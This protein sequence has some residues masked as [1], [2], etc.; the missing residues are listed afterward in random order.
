MV[1]LNTNS[2]I[3]EEVFSSLEYV[4]EIPS[5][6]LDFVR[7]K[8]FKRP[9][10]PYRLF[11]A[12][13]RQG[14]TFYEAAKQLHFRAAALM[15]YYAFLNLAKARIALTEPLFVTARVG[16]GLTERRFSPGPLSRQAV[17]TTNGSGVFPKFYEMEMRRAIPS[18]LRLSILT[19]FAY[20]SDVKSEFERAYQSL[21]RLCPSKCRF[22]SHQASRI[23][24]PYVA[25]LGF[26]KLRPYKKALSDFGKYFEMVQPNREL[27]HGVFDIRAES[28]LNYTYFQS[29][30]TYPWIQDD[31]IQHGAMTQDVLGACSQLYEAKIYDD[32]FDFKLA[33]PLR[34]N[35]QIPFNQPLSIYAAMFYIGSLVR[36]HPDYLEMLLDSKAA[37]IIERFVTGSSIT[38]LRYIANAILE[39]NYIYSGR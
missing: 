7:Q 12:Y 16:H 19:L 36:Y 38:F 26:E 27:V 20:C 1:N 22:A 32:D 2:P 30:T 8:G 11:R 17:Y 21:N 9:K 15:Y 13:V 23:S 5:V 35:H 24:W 37:W 28:H 34:L 33:P 18:G 6:G 3:D 10:T 14:R 29:R 39:T 4:S 31:V 25:V